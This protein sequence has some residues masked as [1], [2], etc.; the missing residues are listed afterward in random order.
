M[1]DIYKRLAATFAAAPDDHKSVPSLALDCEVVSER[2]LLGRAIRDIEIEIQIGKLFACVKEESPFVFIKISYQLQGFVTKADPVKV[3]T[4]S[5]LGVLPYPTYVGIDTTREHP[6]LV[7]SV[8]RQGDGTS[9]WLVEPRWTE[10]L[11][12]LKKHV[13]A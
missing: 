3:V 2:L 1:S 6:R 13:P 9:Y 7:E 12:W 4:L 5:D 11:Q 8:G 10:T